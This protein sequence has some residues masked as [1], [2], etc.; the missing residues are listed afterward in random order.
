MPSAVIRSFS[1]DKDER[2]L[3]VEF[4]TGRRYAYLEVPEDVAAQMRAAFAKGEF[5]NREIRGRYRFVKLSP[6]AESVRKVIE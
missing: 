1:Y 4:T 5:F 6:S 2:Q 3:E